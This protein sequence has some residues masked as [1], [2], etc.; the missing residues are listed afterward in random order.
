MQLKKKPRK[1]RSHRWMAFMI[2]VGAG[3]GAFTISEIA[4]SSVEGTWTSETP[5]L[6]THMA[7]Y[8]A[9][10]GLGGHLRAV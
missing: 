3:V 1:E 9:A 4:Y 10:W 5:L 6:P 8:L 7:S 2:A